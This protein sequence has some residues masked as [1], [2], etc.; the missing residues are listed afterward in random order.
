MDE[1]LFEITTQSNNT[2]EILDDIENLLIED[3][4][5]DK[6][7]TM[8]KDIA[9]RE[10]QGDLEIYPKVVL[11]HIKESYVYQ[12]R[13]VLVKNNSSSIK[14]QDKFID[15]IIL[16][17]VPMKVEDSDKD[18]IRSFMRNLAHEDYIKKLI[19]KE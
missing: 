1:I 2:Y 17:L 9:Y 3:N 5:I 15:L 14:W 16:I 10:A 7:N 4:V 11:P 12:T 6:Q 8:I 19:T 18:L 13:I